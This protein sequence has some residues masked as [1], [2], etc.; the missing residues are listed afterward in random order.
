IE[1]GPYR[2][3]RV[4]EERRG[5]VIHR[6]WHYIPRRQSAL[7]RAAYEASF[8][9]HA[10]LRRSPGTDVVLGVI[11]SL[12]AG[13]I[14]RTYARR[15]GCAYGIIVQDLPAQAARQSGITRTDA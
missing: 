2:R 8:F 7:R 12:S 15:R 13:A 9:A 11:P 4:Q 14:A 10:A 3:P 5:V 6:L 1:P